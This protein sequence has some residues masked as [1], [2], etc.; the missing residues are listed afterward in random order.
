MSETGRYL[1]GL[2]SSG[3]SG[4]HTSSGTRSTDQ[5][6]AIAE[7]LADM[8]GDDMSEVTQLPVPLEMEQGPSDDE[9]LELDKEAQV[10]VDDFDKI[11]AELGITPDGKDAEDYVPE[12]DGG[13][14][15]DY[16][17][18]GIG[19]ADEYEWVVQ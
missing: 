8:E 16:R 19:D 17:V 9:V 15:D 7:Q 4:I 18:V 6:D 2:R 1:T 12:T 14:R 11:C 3:A 5:R 10:I 13:G